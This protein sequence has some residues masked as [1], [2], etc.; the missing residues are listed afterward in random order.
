M[1]K[2]NTF[3]QS[4]ASMPT[5]C[6]GVASALTSVCR[7][8]PPKQPVL[9]T[10]TKLI[11]ETNKITKAIGFMNEDLLN[12]KKSPRSAMAPNTINQIKS[13]AAKS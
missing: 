10:N 13:N 5:P 2:Y 11:S 6:M 3:N 12:V 4:C 1:Q 8:C 7:I 9:A